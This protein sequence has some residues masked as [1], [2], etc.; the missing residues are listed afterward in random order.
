MPQAQFLQLSTAS[1]PHGSFVPDAL[2]VSS[3]SGRS[4]ATTLSCFRCR[5]DQQRP[6]SPPPPPLCPCLITGA[7][8]QGLL[9]ASLSL[10][11]ASCLCLP[12]VT[13]C[14]PPASIP[15]SLPLPHCSLFLPPRPQ[16]CSRREGTSEAAPEAV[17]QAV[18]GGCQ[19]GWGQLLSVTNAVE[20]G[21]CRW[22]TVAGHRLGPLEGGGY[23][24]PF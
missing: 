3:T 11:P 8:A 9:F 23:L 12:P 10:S 18:G 7:G 1:P 5:E 17:T 6:T 22:G 4:E 13:S 19:S 15:S 16:A 21:T 14:P 2:H 20:V 24:P